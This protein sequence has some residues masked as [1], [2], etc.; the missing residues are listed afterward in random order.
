MRCCLHARTPAPVIGLVVA[1]VTPCLALSQ[2]QS[3][4]ARTDLSSNRLARPALTA[5]QP[6][7][8]IRLDGV[9]D[10]PSWAVTDSIADLTQIEPREGSVPAARTV[11]RV[12]ASG[13]EIIIGARAEYVSICDLCKL[14]ARATRAAPATV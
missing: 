11:V 10:E 5:G 8:R 9:L 13:D 4:R 7:G 3:A 12:L 14:A 2:T 1:V 6:S